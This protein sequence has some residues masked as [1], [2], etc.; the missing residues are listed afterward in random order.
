M[1][2]LAVSHDVSGPPPAHWRD[3]TALP[4][5]DHTVRFALAEVADPE[6]DAEREPD[7]VLVRVRGFS[8]NYRERAVISLGHASPPRLGLG[9]EFVGEV[10]AIGRN[11]GHLRRGQRVMGEMAW[12]TNGIPRVIGGVATNTASHQLLKLH[13]GKLVPVPDGMSDELAAGFVLGAQTAYS[14]IRRLGLEAGE[15]VLV[16]AATS[17]TSLF[18]IQILRALPVKVVALTTSADV[19]YRL[20]A[21][22]ATEVV[23]LLSR[24]RTRPLEECSRRIGGFDAVVDPFADTY[25][26]AVVGTLAFFSRYVTCGVA[27]QG[28]VDAAVE[29]TAEA[30]A[31]ARWSDV[32]PQLILRNATV[33][34]NCLGMREDLEAAIRDWTEGKLGVILD[35]VHRDGSLAPF[36]ERT[37]NA[38]DRFG[39]VVYLYS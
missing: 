3:W 22:G 18:A 35:S 7:H 37:F 11:A 2:T 29:A 4:V 5:G 21:L 8:L 19:E 28:A 12:P 17:N 27:L 34:G 6:F 32:L 25:L 20:K 15:N 13:Y 30:E 10:V 39:K 38:T 24:S 23:R 26:P 9:S 16:T 33:M 36:V 31:R 1:L 14:M